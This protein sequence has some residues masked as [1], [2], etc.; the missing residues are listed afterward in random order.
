[1]TTKEKK[2]SGVKKHNEKVKAEKAKAVKDA[3]NILKIQG[4]FTLKQL[5]DEAGVSKTYF[6]KHPDMR[7]LAEVY[8]SPTCGCRTRNKDTQETHIQLLKKENKKLSDEIKEM[9]KE[10]REEVKYKEKYEMAQEEIKKLKE[11]LEKS[12]IDNLPDFL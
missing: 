8:M 4:T 10:E 5:C 6:K 3:I 7:A 11:Q 9:Q 2:M 1:M 12:Y